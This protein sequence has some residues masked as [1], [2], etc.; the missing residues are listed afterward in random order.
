MWIRS[1]K[2][3]SCG[4]NHIIALQWL[5][6]PFKLITD[7]HPKLPKYGPNTL[8]GLTFRHSTNFIPVTADSWMLYKACSPFLI[9]LWSPCFLLLKCP[10]WL[11]PPQL[12]LILKTI[13]QVPRLCL[14]HPCVPSIYLN[15]WQRAETQY[16][17]NEWIFISFSKT[18]F[19]IKPFPIPFST[20]PQSAVLEFFCGTPYI[21][22]GITVTCLF[23]SSSPSLCP[24]P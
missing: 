15:D 19:L 1:C 21:Q 9:C 6:L 11:P 22:R 14:D 5:P 7:R 18:S 23:L 2:W 8:P 12:N 24:P 13:S 10:S 16:A 4:Y 20:G 17:L 3:P